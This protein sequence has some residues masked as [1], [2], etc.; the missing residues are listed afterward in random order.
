[1]TG[2]HR[3]LRPP[4]WHDHGRGGDD[5]VC[6]ITNDDVGASLTVTKVVL[7]DS[8]GDA[9]W[10]SQL[11]GHRR[12]GHRVRGRLLQHVPVNAGTHTVSETAARPATRGHI[13]L[14][15]RRDR[16]RRQLHLR[17]SRTTTC[18]GRS[19]R[20]RPSTTTT[21]ARPGPRTSLLRSQR[22]GHSF[23]AD[24][25][26]VINVRRRKLLGHRAALTGYATTYANSQNAD[27]NSNSLALA[28]RSARP[29]RSP[30]MTSPGA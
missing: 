13:R 3:R 6:T 20:S 2:D 12:C 10:T 1:M 14:H 8:G 9:T 15:G 11:L 26:N 7:N 17:R 5:R 29:A 22:P 19:P 4:K 18:P 25:T 27:A 23:E 28:W 21:A 16:A 24:C 30:T